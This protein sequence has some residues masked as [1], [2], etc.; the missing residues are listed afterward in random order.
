[1]ASK[2]TGLVITAVVLALLLGGLYFWRQAAQPQ[3]GGWQQQAVPVEAIT[4]QPR[5]LTDTISVVGELRAIHEVM[6]APEVAGRVTAINFSSGDEIEAGT[7]LVNLFSGEEKAALQAA[8]ASLQLAETQLQRTRELAPL[9]A[10]SKE[11][12]NQRVAEFEQAS[13]SVEQ[14][15]VRLKL[16]SVNAPFA[17]SL[18]IRQINE[19]QYLNPGDEIVSLT[20]LST[21][22][23]DFAV[24]QQQL[25][26]LK[27]GATVKVSADAYADNT[28][29]ATLDTIDPQLDPQTRNVKVRATLSNDEKLLRPSMYVEASIDAGAESDAIVLPVTAVMYTA[30]GNSVAVVRGDNATQNGNIEFVGVKAG[31][32]IGNEVII[33]SGL[34]AGDVVVT[35]G[36]NRL[37]PQA[38]VTVVPAQEH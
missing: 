1:M 37:Q 6:L 8:Q 17:G 9:G 30:Q 3:G 28:F 26:L 20:D 29:T 11:L 19:G 13:A 16:K 2:I 21:L 27:A 10:E 32:R 22:Y 34:T 33:E 18:G 7:T 23:V 15:Q 5:Q 4:V 12:L 24:P 14:A 38:P 35:A 36:Q 25:A 31:R